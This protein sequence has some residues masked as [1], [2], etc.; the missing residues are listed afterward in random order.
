MVDDRPTGSD[1]D[2]GLLLNLP[3]ELRPTSP[4]ATL[5]VKDRGEP[6]DVMIVGTSFSG[7]LIDVMMRQRL[8]SE[9]TLLNYFRF[10]VAYSSADRP[11]VA[12]DQPAAVLFPAALRRV[13]A[14][15]LE[16]NAPAVTSL[17]VPAF[18]DAVKALQGPS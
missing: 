9:I 16:V 10:P 2:T 4:H 5:A 13:D 18:L 12:L 7:G 8:A 15:I 17:H 1:A 3:V 11:G 14:V 6:I